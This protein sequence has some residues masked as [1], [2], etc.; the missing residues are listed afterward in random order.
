M[1]R[2]D[3]NDLYDK[4]ADIINLSYKNIE[5]IDHNTLSSYVV[6]H[7]NLNNNSIRRI[8][9]S[10]FINVI[11]LKTLYLSFNL[12]ESIGRSSF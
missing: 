9:D 11:N 3:R 2:S 5:Q 10:S 8:Y 7:L 6:Q 1:Y 4:K 12:I